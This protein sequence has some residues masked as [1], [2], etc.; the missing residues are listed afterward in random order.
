[1]DKIRKV[2]AIQHN[3]T[4]RIYIGSTTNVDTRYLAHIGAL[5]AGKHKV[6]DMQADFNEYGEDY[7]LFVLD[8]INEFADRIKEYEWMDRY[9]TF[10]RGVGYN[11]KDHA[12]KSRIINNT[13]PYKDGLPDLHPDAT[14]RK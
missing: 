2:Y 4:K 9:D 13:P 7:S 1:M 8:E 5:R 6:E 11:Y 3:V 12:K 10:T 14:E